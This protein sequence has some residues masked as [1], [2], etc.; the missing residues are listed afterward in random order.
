LKCLE[1]DPAKVSKRRAFAEDLER[2]LR[3]D[4]PRPAHRMIIASQMDST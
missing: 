4:H 3:H 2:W 1:K